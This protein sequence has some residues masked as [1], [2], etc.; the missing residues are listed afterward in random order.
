VLIVGWVEAVVVVVVREP[1]EEV[2][3]FVVVCCLWV[4]LL[5]AVVWV[6]VREAMEAAPAQGSEALERLLWW[7]SNL[8][9]L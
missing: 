8:V 6:V 1:L 2:V 4:C 5:R 7:L 9:P 3:L